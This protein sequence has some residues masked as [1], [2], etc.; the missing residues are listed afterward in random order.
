MSVNEES[1]IRLAEKTPSG[2]MAVAAEVADN[3]ETD[4]EPENN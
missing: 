4:M 1:T 3:D 2:G